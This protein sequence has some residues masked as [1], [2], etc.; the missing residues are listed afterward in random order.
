VSWDLYSKALLKE[1]PQDFVTY[2]VPGAQ[3]VSALEGQFQTQ[4]SSFK[5]RE[6]RADRMIKATYQGK[7]FLINIEFQVKKDGRMGERLLGYSY[8]GTRQHKLDVLSCVI[9]LKS[10][11]NPPRP[12]L[13]RILP[14][15]YR[16]IL[17]NYVSVQLA[18]MPVEELRRHNLDALRPLMLLCKDGATYAVLEEV[19]MHLQKKNYGELLA[20]TRFFAGMVFSSKEDRAY[21][22]RRFAMI[23][24]FLWE[25]SWTYRQTVEQGIAKGEAKGLLVMRESIEDIVQARFPA[26]LTLTKNRIEK[27]TDLEKLRQISLTISTARSAREVKKFLL[28]LK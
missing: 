28:A 26:L 9:Y 8:E 5:K 19:L 24:E 20:A 7:P 22:E 15:A 2:F 13:D 6:V 11:S 23:D 10:V 21:L 18:E 4:A 14:H 27:V 3:Y 16:S 1:C 17:F 25:N 12:P